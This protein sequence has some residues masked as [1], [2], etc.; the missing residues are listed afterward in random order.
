MGIALPDLLPFGFKQINTG[1]IDDDYRADDIPDALDKI[2]FNSQILKE[3]LREKL[4][5]NRI[6]YIAPSGSDLNTG[7]SSTSSLQTISKAIEIVYNQL[8][9]NGYIVTLSLGDGAYT[10]QL[11]FDGLPLGAH[12]V[13]FPIVLQGNASNAALVYI[14]TPGLQDGE[15]CISLTNG[16]RVAVNNVKLGAASS[17]GATNRFGIYVKD[18]SKIF[19]KKVEFSSLPLNGIC[20]AAENS[21]VLISTSLK[22]TGNAKNFLSLRKNAIALSVDGV[23]T[24]SVT[25]NPEFVYLFDIQEA[26]SV[27]WNQSS[28]AVTFNGTAQGK[29]YL[30]DS[31]SSINVD[32]YPTNMVEGEEVA[33]LI[34]G[35]AIIN[36]AVE[37]KKSAIVRSTLQVHEATTLNSTLLVGEDAT[38]N[39]KLTVGKKASFLEDFS[40]AGSSTFQSIGAEDITSSTGTFSSLDVTGI[41]TLKDLQ[42][43]NA[44]FAGTVAFSG[45]VFVTGAFNLPDGSVT[46]SNLSAANGQE[47]DILDISTGELRW[48]NRL[49]QVEDFLP[50]LAP[51]DSPEFIG[52]PL[53]PTAAEEAD[54]EQLATTAFVKRAIN[55]LKNNLEETIAARLPIGTIVI[56]HS[57]VSTIPSGF[58]LCNGENSTPDLRDKFVFG[59]GQQEGHDHCVGEIGGAEKVTVPSQTFATTEEFVR[60]GSMYAVGHALT[61]AEMPPHR[62]A[63]QP[64][65]LYNGGNEYSIEFPDGDGGKKSSGDGGSSY[66]VS[67]VLNSPEGSGGV[68]GHTLA[69]NSDLHDHKITIPS[70]EVNVMPPYSVRAY[71]MR[72]L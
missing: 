45:E 28:T 72:V 70:I 62:H 34:G 55:S 13:E 25:N 18:S 2:N 10:D 37:L 12:T 53:A 40:V 15:S 39:K 47:K 46:K 59:A 8:D 69:G 16:A 57:D 17:L 41:T 63:D 42:V 36:G 58:A 65:L 3:H 35:E 54:N 50:S 33:F 32:S 23:T 66:Y 21:F 44:V 11:I 67:R 38:L 64:F 56:W 43:D 1:I 61:L 30:K 7:R 68:H 20:I 4:Q 48:S 14:Q 71:M 6:Y 5:A 60:P 19:L 31:L 26:S 29:E 22:V 49:T 52:V 9:L 27:L 24:I 51:V